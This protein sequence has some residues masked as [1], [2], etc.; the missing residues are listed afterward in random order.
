MFTAALQ[1]IGRRQ[2]ER[3]RAVL[4]KNR[5][6]YPH[7]GVGKVGDSLRADGIEPGVHLLL[8]QLADNGQVL[9]VLGEGIARHLAEGVGVTALEKVH[10]KGSVRALK[11]KSLL[12]M[13]PHLVALHGGEL[14]NLQGPE[15]HNRQRVLG[16]VLVL[17]LGNLGPPRSLEV[18]LDLA[19]GVGVV[20]QDGSLV[21]AGD[22]HSAVLF[23][24]RNVN[25]QGSV[26]LLRVHLIGDD[27]SG[28]RDGGMGH[29]LPAV[30]H[31]VVQGLF[32]GLQRNAQKQ[33]G[34]K[35]YLS[36]FF[37]GRM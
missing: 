5:R 10:G 25:V 19:N 21:A 4:F 31:A 37:A 24:A 28:R 26:T 32:L 29:G 16:H 11:S 2:K 27:L 8:A 17:F 6:T 1:G 20:L 14:H 22:F 9:S 13:E 15:V 18:R 30:K 35:E 34:E 23:L 36:H 3:P 33:A 12:G 7:G